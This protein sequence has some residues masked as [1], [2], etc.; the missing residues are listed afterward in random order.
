VRAFWPRISI[1]D[2]MNAPPPI[3]VRRVRTVE[4]VEAARAAT[5]RGRPLL[6]V[7]KAAWCERCPAF[8]EAVEQ[9][10]TM[11]DFDRCYTDANDTELA[12]HHEIAMLP[13]FVLYTAP[14]AA[15]IVRAAATPAQVTES[16]RGHCAPCLVLDADF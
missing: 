13:A 7:V 5:A 6:L 15:P 14:D 11:Y 16:V 9:L 12:E 10:A 4:E 3:E 2:G 8:G 1:L